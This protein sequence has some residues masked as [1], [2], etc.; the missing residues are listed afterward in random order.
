MRKPK[1]D[2]EL[3]RLIEGKLRKPVPTQLW[4]YLRENHW[5]E[6]VLGSPTENDY[7]ETLAFLLRQAR[8]LSRIIQ[9]GSGERRTVHRSQPSTSATAVMVSAVL[10][11]CYAPLAEAYRRKWLG[12][13][14]LTP[15]E[16]TNWL[17]EQA[18][19]P[20]EETKVIAEEGDFVQCA[21]LFLLAQKRACQVS[22]NPAL[23]ELW[24]LA[25]RLEEDCLWSEEETLLFVL[26]AQVPSACN[27]VASVRH[28]APFVVPTV[29]LTVPLWTAPEEV[30]RVYTRLR[31]EYRPTERFRPPSRRFAEGIRALVQ[32]RLRGQSTKDAAARVGV[33]PVHLVKWYSL[34]RRRLTSLLRIGG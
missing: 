14:L 19:Q 4:H 26:C 10:A 28:G 23:Y 34:A 20:L 25:K 30:E 1:T 7:K 13:R 8:L 2:T 12:G 15:E 21:G 6:D 17:Q 29:T 11:E 31:A 22:R 3:R 18:K 9:A 24:W 33:T 32:A 5:T 16:V 27:I